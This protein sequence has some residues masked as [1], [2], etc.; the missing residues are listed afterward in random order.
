MEQQHA[1]VPDRWLLALQIGEERVDCRAPLDRESPRLRLECKLQP[2]DA[3]DGRATSQ[4]LHPRRLAG[5][6]DEFVGVGL[7]HVDIRL[8]DVRRR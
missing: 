1:A 6:I 8:G 4:L 7:G 3:M 2:V 5:R